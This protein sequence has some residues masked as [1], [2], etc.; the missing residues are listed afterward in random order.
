MI[1]RVPMR[2]WDFQTTLRFPSSAEEFAVS[3]ND[4]PGN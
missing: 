2:A 1:S 3:Y 4:T